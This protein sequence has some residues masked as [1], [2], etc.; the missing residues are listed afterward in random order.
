MFKQ[1]ISRPYRTETIFGTPDFF[2][3][4][5]RLKQIKTLFDKGYIGERQ[6]NLIKNI[7]NIDFPELNK[8][9]ASTPFT[10][11]KQNDAYTSIS[12]LWEYLKDDFRDE[13]ECNF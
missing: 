9:A 5:T 7:L 6:S 8:D 2:S 3:L 4:K 1:L 13:L 12:Y 11:Q 10:I